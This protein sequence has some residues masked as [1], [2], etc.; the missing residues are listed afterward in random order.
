MQVCRHSVPDAQESHGRSEHVG[1]CLTVKRHFGDR[2]AP[3]V[4]DMAI[5]S[6]GTKQQAA[7]IRRPVQQLQ[8]HIQLLSPD[9]VA[10]KEAGR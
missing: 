7:T 1:T 4:N 3:C 9:S 8:L 10:C 5:P 6:C 2:I